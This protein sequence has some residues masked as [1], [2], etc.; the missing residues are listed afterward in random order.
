MTVP[1]AIATSE[2]E[3]SPL[4][5][6]PRACAVVVDYEGRPADR[7][8]SGGWRSA[9]FIIGVE[10]AERFAFTGISSNL[11]TY[12]TGSLGQSKARAAENVNTWNGVSS[13]S[14]LLGAFI[15]DSYLG[16][17]RTVVI[18]SLLYVLG[19]GLLTLSAVLPSLSSLDCQNGAEIISI[20]C[21]PLWFQEI[22]FFFSLYLVAVALGGH[23][24][25][26]L[27]FG[28]DQFDGQDS[29]ES[30]SKSSF[31]NWWA[32]GVIS[33][34][35]VALLFL[36]YIQ[37]NLSW[38]LGFGIP[39][40]SMVI[41]LV[42][43]L[44]GTRTYR[45][46][47]KSQEKNP[48]FRIGKVFAKA[49]RNWQ[50]SSSVILVEMEAQGTLP[51]ENSQ[52]FRFLYKALL[53]PVGSKEEGGECRV[54]D[55]EDAKAIL[56]LVPI[57]VSCLVYAI[58]Y[59][60]C[61]TFFTEQGATMDRSIWPGFDIP[62][63]SLLLFI[64]FSII[65]F[66]PIYDRLLVPFTRA[67]IGKPSGITMLQRIGIGLLI[68]IVVMI[69]AALV[70]TK[71]RETALEFG[72]VDK[73]EETVPMS[74]WWLV[75]QYIL[76]GIA[77]V[78]TLTG[79]QE[80][81]YDQVPNELRSAG[82]FGG[83]G[84]PNLR[85]KFTGCHDWFL[86]KALLTPVGSKEE[87]GECRVGDVEDAKAI[88]SLVPIW[89][90]CLVYAIMY[91]QCSTFFTE[92]GATMDRSI[93]PGFDIP[94][95]SLLLFITFSIIFFI[96]IYDRLL[97]PFTRALT[98]KPSGITMLQRIGIGLL[99]SIVVMIIAALVE[100]KRRETALEF[101]LVDEPEETVPMSFWW[102]VPQYILLGIADVFT[103]TGWQ[104][105]FY[106]QAPNELRSA[107]ISLYLS[108]IGVGSFLSSFLIFIIDEATGGEDGGG[109]FS[110][111]LNRA[112]LDYFYWLLAGLST[113]ALV[114]YLYFTKTYIYR[115]G[116][117][118]IRR[119]YGN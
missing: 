91:A 75:P 85:C 8:R 79:L 86:Y 69:I 118:N 59:A 37:D 115:Q 17:Y 89:V 74:F 95:A 103:L 40:I 38:G 14:P 67:L 113:V 53:T 102:L 119:N 32:F 72:L 93:W 28:A 42:V 43:F 26:V 87:G 9:F 51:D 31:F 48:F 66:I 65:F 13:I 33:G 62:P 57:W 101:G 11:I 99:I 36:N 83:M 47:I 108:I 15:A 30:K 58:M 2:P 104:E 105:L 55:V 3:S 100:T 107:G 6:Y 109:W 21:P 80:L 20:S 64:T 92:Q 52:Q 106:D 49:A 81:F 46:T 27:A 34:P 54:G 82:E 22:L 88:L 12:L 23:K 84:M 25:C 114:S 61:S 77:D 76:L 41:A 73:P 35:T 117:V 1:T 24:P 112:H 90:S 4:L 116:S 56:S 7:S 18:A 78:F 44:I 71:R 50:S 16:R 45:Y 29:E 98:G 60:Q 97:V 96:P 10:V 110:D 63:A 5:H 19:L 94:P 39:C 70:E 68:S 111:N